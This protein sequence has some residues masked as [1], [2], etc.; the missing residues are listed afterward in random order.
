MPHFRLLGWRPAAALTLAVFAWLPCNDQTVASE[1]V[2]FVSPDG[3]DTWSGRLPDA[4]PKRTD[5][6]WRTLA[7]AC[8]AVRPGDTCRLREGVYREVL[9]PLQSGTASAPIVFEATDGETVLL[10]GADSVGGWQPTG[11]GL[12]KAPFAW[13]LKDENQLFAG[14]QMLTEARWPNLQGTLLTPARATVDSGTPDTIVDR[15]LPGDDDFWKGSVL[16]CAG[17][18]R[19]YCWSAT[20]T[21]FDSRTKTLSFDKSQPNKWYTP[22]QGNEYVLMGIRGALD[23]E[24]EWWLDRKSK[25][26][27][28]RPL[29]DKD[30]NTQAIE[31]K[32][33]IYTMDLSGRAYIRVSGIQ[34]RAG[35]IRA[36]ADSHHLLFE[37]LR[38]QY[39]GHSYVNDVSDRASVLIRGHHIELNGC[40]LAYAS[41]SLV[42][43]DGHDNRMVNC[44]LHDGDYA[45]KWKGAASFSG[46]RQ[47]ISHNTIQDSGRDVCSVH[48]LME[49]LIQYNDLSNAG[50]LT[51]DL[52]MTYGHNTD[53]MG[54][55]IRYNWVH[56]N[57]AR[58]HTAGIYFDHCSHNA[59]IHHNV[60]WNVRG[61]PLQVNNP[62][63]FMLCYNNTLINSGRISTFDHSHRNDLFGSRFQNNILAAEL[64]LPTHV[65]TQPNLINPN[66]GPIDPENHRFEL[67][68]TSPA[69]GAGVPLPGISVGTGGR[70]PDMGACPPTWKAGHDFKK[71]PEAKWDVSE[72]VFSNAIRNAAFELGTTEFWTASGTGTASIVKG[73]GWG[74]GFGR[75]DVQKTGTSKHELKLTGKARVEQTVKNLHPNTS[76]QLSAWLKVTDEKSPVVLGVCG[77]SGPD[78]TIVCTDE[79]W[80]RKTVGF[81][82]GTDATGTT[83][84]VAQDSS[85]GEA[86]A[87][88][89]GLPRSPR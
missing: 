23:A 69:R 41:G 76:Y 61:M 6:P 87:D 28:L 35:G 63:Y 54:T 37:N 18:H 53:F 57:L 49:S 25:T 12:F 19:W 29:G 24:G 78:V 88:N 65:V 59:I 84:F 3:D 73:N 67:A 72:A 14:D 75:G 89:L 42:R 68:P 11:D 27:W 2:Y 52:G 38:G 15:E 1:N 43:M 21:A 22:R 80:E 70:P 77:H 4:N 79:S 51:S 74:N 36:D 56:D 85:A 46:R 64:K 20:V 83:V 26:L 30:P 10:S 32:R 40:E 66:P 71:A 31:A 50:W 81:T 82:T 7:K 39:I 58:G 17:G 55:V 60:V 62:S 9:K 44:F 86:F 8:A 47:L 48:G 5:G 45:G 34:F 13:D 33:R 16:W